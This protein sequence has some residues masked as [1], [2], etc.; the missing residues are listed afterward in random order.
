MQ[1][2]ETNG[3]TSTQIRALET[4]KIHKTSLSPITQHNIVEYKNVNKHQNHYQNDKSIIMIVTIIVLII[5]II[6]IIIIIRIIIIIIIM[7]IIVIINKIK[8]NQ[9][10]I[11]DIKLSDVSKYFRESILTESPGTLDNIL[12]SDLFINAK[13]LNLF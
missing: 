11:S 7:I 13:L 9:E 1:H 3:N 5:I 6:T 8:S 12:N 4:K 2:Y 10:F